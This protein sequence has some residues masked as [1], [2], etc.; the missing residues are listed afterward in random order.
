MNLPELEHI[1][2]PESTVLRTAL[3]IDDR[4]VLERLRRLL[5]KEEGIEL[6]GGGGDPDLAEPSLA[7]APDLVFLECTGQGLARAAK[8]TDR[9]PS[10]R[11]SVVLLGKPERAAEAWQVHADDYLAEPLT[12]GRVHA[13]ATRVRIRRELDQSRELNQHLLDLIRSLG[14]QKSFLRRLTVKKEGR[15]LVL[16]ADR[17]DWIDAA[18]N[19]VRLNVSGKRYRLR[20]SIGRLERRLDP[21][22]FLRI[23]RSTIVNL[24]RIREIRSLRHGEYLLILRCGQRLTL[25]RGYRSHLD[26][27]LG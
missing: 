1:A 14:E 12:A 5:A 6:I 23:H 8:L 17:V 2:R 26:H 15:M 20:E 7:A 21:E 22:H 9:A 10:R 13:V 24:D 4:M 3:V 11:P 18:R 16:D 27:L 19:Y 25:S